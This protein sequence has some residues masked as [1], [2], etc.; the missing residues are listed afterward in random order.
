MAVITIPNPVDNEA[1]T[2]P[3]YSQPNGYKPLAPRH[4][5]SFE[6]YPIVLRIDDLMCIL[7]I[8]RSA[9]YHLVRSGMIRS[10]K[11]G[12]SYRIPRDAVVE[13]LNGTCC[14]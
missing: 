2:S 13:Y 3:T 8:G 5:S 6:D 11:I 1:S 9:A 12:K 14:K 4:V 7:S 10:I